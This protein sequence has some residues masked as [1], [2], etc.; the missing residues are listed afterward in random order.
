MLRT[1]LFVSALLFSFLASAQMTLADGAVRYG[2]EWIDYDATYLRVSV[3]EDGVYRLSP[4]DLRA[5]GFDFAA[6]GNTDWKLE[7]D[8]AVVPVLVDRDGLLFYGEKNRGELDRFL[9]RDAE[10]MQLNGRHSMHNDTA[11]YYLSTGKDGLFYSD[12][13]PTG[14]ATP[15]NQITR[16]AEVVFGDHHSKLFTRT[17]DGTS[18]YYSHYELAEGFGLRSNNDLLSTNNQNQT[19]FDI[20]LPG[21]LGGA[22]TL[23]MRFGLA[24]DE[25]RQAVSVDGQ[26]LTTVTG[27]RWSVEQIGLPFTAGADEASVLLEGSASDRDKANVAWAR[28]TYPAELSGTDLAHFLAPASAQN[29]SL[30]LRNLGAGAGAMYVLDA[31][32]M[33]SIS[34]TPDGDGTNFELPGRP[35]GAKYHLV[36]GNTALRPAGITA[37]NFSPLVADNSSVDYLLVTSERLAGAEL[38]A[39]ANYRRS[40]AGGGYNVQ[41]VTVEELYEQFS[42]GVRRHPLAIRNFVAAVGEAS[43]TLRYLFLVGK[44]REFNALRTA[45]QLA[46]ARETFFL[47]SFGLPASDNLLTAPVDGVT[48]AVATGRLAAINRQELS[49]YLTKLRDV[50]SQV[51]L[52]GQTLEDRDWMKQFI[53]LGGGGVIGEQNSIRTRLGILERTIENSDL[54][55]NVTGFFKTSTDVLE[56]SQQDAI[57]NRINAGAGVITFYG[58]S[59]TSG[60]DFSIDDPANYNNKGRYPYM[61]SLGCYS[62]DAFGQARSISEKFIFLPNKG[63]ITFAA[64]KGIGY[65]SALGTWANNLYDLTGNELYGQGVGDVMKANIAHFAE[66]NNFTVRLLTEQFALSGDPAYRIHPRPGPDVVVDARSVQFMPDVVPAQNPTF[67]VSFRV[68]NIGSEGG[69][70]SITVRFNQELPNREIRTVGTL[71]M[72]TPRYDEEV[73]VT[74]PNVGL[75]AVGQNRFFI[76]LDSEFDLAEAPAPAAENNNNLVSG[77]RDGIPLTFIANTAKVAFPPQF[78]VVTGDVELVSSTTD[79]LAEEREYLLQ[80][81]RSKD[82][83]DL[84]VDDRITSPGGVIRQPLSLSMTDSTTYFWRISP[85]S[86]FTEGAGYIWSE[87]SFTWLAGDPTSKPYWAQQHPG[88]LIE[89][90]FEN[91]KADASSREWGFARNATDIRVFNGIYED[92]FFPRFMRNQQRLASPFRWEE[93]SGISVLVMDSLNNKWSTNPGAGEYNTRARVADTWNFNTRTEAGR[94][95]LIDFIQNGIP[96]GKYVFV[97]SLQRGNTLNYYNDG[98]VD[99][100]ATLGTTIFDV[101]E[102][103]GA[104]EIK[105]LTTVGSVPYALA[106]QK[107]LG[108]MGEVMAEEITDEI[109][110]RV[111]VFANWDEGVWSSA[112]AGPAKEWRS[113]NLDL[114]AAGLEPADSAVVSVIGE[115][116]TGNLTPLKTIPHLFLDN[117]QLDIDLSDI[118]ARTYPRLNFDVKLLDEENRTVPSVNTF[119]LDYAGVGD[120]AVAPKA[121]FVTPDSLERGQPALVSVGYE[122][123][124]DVAMDSLLVS[125]RLIDAQNNVTTTV[126][127]QPPLAGMAS[128]RVDFNVPTE[129]I[130]SNVRY[131]VVVNPE[132]DQPED[133]LFNNVLNSGFKI[134]RDAVAPVLTV[135][136]DGQRIND[137]ALVSGLPEIRIQLRDDNRFLRLNDTAAYQIRLT[138]PDGSRETIALSDSRVE[139]L[140][141][142]DEENEAEIFFRPELLQ[143]G[144]YELE[145]NGRDRSDNSSGKLNYRRTFEVI[146]EMRIGN[147]LAYPNPFTTQTRFVYTLTGNDL[148]STFRIQIMTVSGRVVRDIDLLATETLKVGTHRTDFAWDGTDEYGDLLANGVYLYRVIS[149]DT[150]GG[151]LKKQDTNTDQYFERGLGKVVILR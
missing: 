76:S 85:D 147:V 45:D 51:N 139:F 29:Q 104:L 64:S 7:H 67:E 119:Y 93:R 108:L 40:P 144:E 44:G 79:A 142:S 141:S 34:G 124:S 39:M 57:F 136:F 112:T 74:L 30:T 113:A 52:G 130:T 16:E 140:P 151:M 114:H 43:P 20:P 24:F 109:E 133:I 88:Q 65:I 19:V 23:E 138:S 4:E 53:H 18:L 83:S 121:T 137:G 77:G 80:V 5:A 66:T 73:T 89:G 96:E 131:E 21:S 61:L 100:E 146:N 41:V 8:G 25:H 84:L 69:R 68:V 82:F 128:G 54:G 101:L 49:I 71:R 59:S 9:F 22:A 12:Y 47:P 115:D 26:L 120:V 62:G 1:V 123:V 36:T 2:H 92:R 129:A 86:I 28:V 150:S 94:A 32:R 35:N 31:D 78:A 37:M 143:D 90:K 149:G 60:F 10:N 98:W 111:T 46:A 95:G 38:D 99:D 103:E 17:S 125:L 13:A 42:Y 14:S 72:L 118:D 63:A 6:V 102:A 15:L 126:K 117:G 135:L 148:P 97:W 48:P 91:I 107:G 50:E 127:R 70:D 132:R 81:S 55:G 116:A 27:N 75:E 11:V 134:G 122:N 110:L 87:S 33:V 145:V 106:F 105:R 3:A 58:H 56:T